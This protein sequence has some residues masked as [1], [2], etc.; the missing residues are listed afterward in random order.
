MSHIE[1]HVAP[2]LNPELWAEVFGHLEQRPES[3]KALG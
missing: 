3:I 1:Q 2:F